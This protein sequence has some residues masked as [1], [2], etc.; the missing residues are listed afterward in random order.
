MSKSKIT[1]ASRNARTHSGRFVARCFY[2]GDHIQRRDIRHSSVEPG[3]KK[4]VFACRRC[5]SY[6]GNYTMSQWLQKLE[7]RRHWPKWCDKT[8]EWAIERAREWV[9][10]DD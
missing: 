3:E 7:D 4:S 2:C 10:S 1:L 6:K 9:M 8:R 5:T